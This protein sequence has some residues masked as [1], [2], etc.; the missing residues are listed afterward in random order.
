MKRVAY[1]PRYLS[2]LRD[3]LSIKGVRRVVMHEPLSNVRPI[4]FLN[5]APDTPK[6]EIWRGLNGAATL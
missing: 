2:Y 5:F 3:T 4:I 6:T 1:E